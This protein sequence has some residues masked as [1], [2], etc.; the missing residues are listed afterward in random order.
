MYLLKIKS[1]YFKDYRQWEKIVKKRAEI[2]H[3]LISSLGKNAII[4]TAVRY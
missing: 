1:S 3:L 4:E 2:K